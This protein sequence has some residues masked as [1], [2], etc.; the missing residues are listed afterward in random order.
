M[1]KTST[2][3]LG[4][5]TAI[6]FGN[7]ANAQ[8]SANKP[9]GKPAAK[10]AAKQPSKEQMDQ[11]AMM[12]KMMEAATPGEMHKMLASL[13]GKWTGETTLWTSPNDPPQ[14]SMGT[15]ENSMIMGGR[16]Q[17]STIKADMGGMPFEGMS[18]LGYDNTRKVFFNT[19]IDN[20]GTG[21]M[22]LEGP[23]DAATKTIILKGTYVDPSTG[24]MQIR[25]TMKMVDDKHQLI[26][27]YTTLPGKKEMK[28]MEIKYTRM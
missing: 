16:Y 28:T 27:M 26:E 9:A 4:I 5:A 15:A 22:E 20:F 11:A 12:Q 18:L 10:S 19:W 1:K 8:S 17:Q 3:L 13:D 25:Q 24:K 14:K 6:M 2:L 21:I 23:Y 7:A